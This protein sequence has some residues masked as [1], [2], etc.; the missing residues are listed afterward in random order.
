VSQGHEEGKKGKQRRRN[1]EAKHQ[2]P[3]KEADAITEK[4]LKKLGRK[5]TKE[6][7]RAPKEKA[8][9]LASM[10]TIVGWR[11]QM[12]FCFHYESTGFRRP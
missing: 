5:A 9:G 10:S 4:Q 8:Q 3:W 7:R 12:L 1:E 11:S 2:W 6:W